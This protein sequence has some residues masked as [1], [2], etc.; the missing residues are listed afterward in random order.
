MMRPLTI[1]RV[2]L[3]TMA[4]AALLAVSAGAADPTVSN[5]RATQLA[6]KTVEVVYDLSGAP[7]GGATV[8]VAFSQD[9]GATYTITP[10][11]AA[12]SGHVGAGI[13]NGTNRRIVW[14]AAATMPAEFYRTTMRAAVTAVD[15]G[16]GGPEITVTL[17]GGV[18]LTLVRIPAGTFMMGSPTTERGRD[19]DETQHQVTLTQDYYLG[20]TEVTQ[21]QWH[22]VMGTPMPTSCGSYGTGDN[23]PVYCVSWDDICGGA[24]GSSCT[25]TSFIGKLNAHLAATGQPGAGKF[26]LPTEAEWER[27]ARGGT[28]GPFSFDTS[29][30]PSW[31]VGCG[32][33]PQAEAYM[34][35]CNNAG[36]TTHAVGQKAPN[37]YDL[38]D[39]HGNEWEWVA[40][41]YGSYPSSAVT[42][43]PG[44]TTGS[45]RV[46]R[47]GGFYGDARGCRSAGRGY[48][49]PGIRYYFYGFR[50]ARSQ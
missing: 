12:L 32:S 40:D 24:T 2:V 23:H 34:W 39:M 21:R 1:S 48:G 8:S 42:D 7:A 30:N 29:A 13:A 11:G 16:G 15:P 5:V 33:F 36:G 28:T 19:S 38:L 14:N 41:W 27:A 18:S 25:S 50:L 4:A 46:F 44:P 31:D 20:K 37:P 43:P 9:S 45:G 17:P 10:A 49:S 22:A 6:D 26:R 3:L 35:W 47:G